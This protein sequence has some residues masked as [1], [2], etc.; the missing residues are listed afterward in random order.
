[1]LSD[2]STTCTGCGSGCSKTS[3]FKTSHGRPLACSGGL[4]PLTP[5]TSPCPAPGRRVDHARP[6]PRRCREGSGDGRTD[7]GAV[8]TEAGPY[9]PALPRERVPS[10]GPGDDVPVA[11]APHPSGELIEVL[12]TELVLRPKR[13]AERVCLPKGGIAGGTVLAE[14]RSSGT[15]VSGRPRAGWAAQPHQSRTSGA[16]GHGRHARARLQSW[17]ESAPVG[18]GLV[19]RHH[20]RRDRPAV[21]DRDAMAFPPQARRGADGPARLSAPVLRAGSMN[22]ATC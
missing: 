8:L 18:G 4:A 13:L 22:C 10:C 11:R 19:L 17:P 15:A 20:A 12:L 3:S 14:L 16:S 1:M 7:R 21:T 9:Q 2:S 6:A 5:S